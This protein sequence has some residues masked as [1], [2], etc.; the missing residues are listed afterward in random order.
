MKNYILILS[1]IVCNACYGQLT[2]STNGPQTHGVIFFGDVERKKDTI[3]C[4]VLFSD[5]SLQMYITEDKRMPIIYDTGT[6]VFPGFGYKQDTSYYKDFQ[7]YPSYFYSVRELHNTAE[8][9]TD[10]DG[11]MCIRNGEVVPCWHDYYQH[12]FYLDKNKQKLHQ[13]I[14]VW[15]AIEVNNHK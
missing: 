11:Q 6:H 12:I 3:K 9:Q 2:L 13:N 5:T 10:P 15:Q 7:V 8:G 14:V 4:F 1:M